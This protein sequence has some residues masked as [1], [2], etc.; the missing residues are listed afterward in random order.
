MYK[1]GVAYLEDGDGSPENIVKMFSVTN[2]LRVT[3]HDF[4]TI[5]LSGSI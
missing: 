1:T 5:T 4:V 2:A 3:I